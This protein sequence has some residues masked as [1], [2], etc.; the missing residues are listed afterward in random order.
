[1][2]GILRKKESVNV[3]IERHSVV[4]ASVVPDK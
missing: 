2:E 3:L 4:N 1:M